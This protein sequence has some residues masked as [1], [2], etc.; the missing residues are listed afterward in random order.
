PVKMR[1]YVGQWLT[2]QTDDQTQRGVGNESALLGDGA[3]LGHT[4]LDRQHKFQLIFGPLTLQQYVRFSPWGQDLPVLCEWVR[5]F[6]G[7]E[8]AWE[9]SLV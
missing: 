6:V 4:V 9:V 5:Q 7:F 2:L 1:E 8:Y 3:I